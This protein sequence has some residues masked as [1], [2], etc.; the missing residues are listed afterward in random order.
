LLQAFLQRIMNGGG[1]I[2]REY[3]LG[4]ARTDLLLTWPYNQG[5]ALQ[6]VVIETKI[7]RGSLKTELAAGLAQTW[8]YM[9][10]SNTSDG[11][12]IIFDRNPKTPWSKK[13][14]KRQ[15][16]YNGLPITVWGA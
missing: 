16:S 10:R 12:L 14:F 2:H 4:R 13:I 1:R 8:G 3:G 7:R 6:Q 15:E 5:Q 11:H 9:D